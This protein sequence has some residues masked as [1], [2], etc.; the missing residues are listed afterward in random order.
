M[1]NHILSTRRIEILAGRDVSF[2]YLAGGQK[3]DYRTPA[4]FR[5]RNAWATKR[6]FKETMLLCAWLGMVNLGHIAL[7]GTS[8]IFR[9]QQ[10]KGSNHGRRDLEEL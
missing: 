1:A 7:D 5:R 10:C 3:P 6:L 4:R 8:H 9:W 2:V